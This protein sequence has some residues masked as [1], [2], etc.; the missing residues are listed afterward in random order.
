VLFGPMIA[1]ASSATP[2]ATVAASI[3]ASAP[4]A[5][6]ASMLTTERDSLCRSCF[7]IT[8]VIRSRPADGLGGLRQRTLIT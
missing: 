1:A 2:S 7:L 5:V 4:T 6:S 8:A 3:P